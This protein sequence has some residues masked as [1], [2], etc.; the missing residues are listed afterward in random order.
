[1]SKKNSDDPAQWRSKAEMQL[2]STSATDG[3]PRS[4]EELLQKLQVYQIELEMQNEALRQAQVELEKSRDLYVDFYD[5]SPVG[6]ITFSHD[7]IIN[8]INL[9][10]AALLGIERGK[11]RHCRFAPFVAPQDRDRWHRYFLSV[12]KH[13]HKE[14]CELQFQRNDGSSFCGLLHCLL[15]ENDGEKSVVR[16]VLTDITKL[17]RAEAEVLSTNIEL[18]ATFDAIPDLLFE[19]GMD[20]RYYNY[21]AYRTDLLA[22]SPDLLLGK[23]IFEVLPP[24]AAQIC[25]SA[26]QEA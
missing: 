4:A 11:L 6:Y 24:E 2:V 15:L 16:A 23:T 26:L 14:E 19:I 5:F 9:T 22:I 18:Q 10:G 3:T 13:G 17:K 25:M 1:M 20:G 7:A 12:L 8:E 21:H